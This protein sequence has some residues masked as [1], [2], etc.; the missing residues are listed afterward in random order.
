MA[1]NLIANTITYLQ[2]TIYCDEQQ[3]NAVIFDLLWRKT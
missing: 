2:P 1:V 3:A